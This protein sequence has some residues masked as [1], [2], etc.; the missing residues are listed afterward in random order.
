M[1]PLSPTA[2][3]LACLLLALTAGA[4]AASSVDLAVAGKI[5]P[6]ACTPRLDEEVRLGGPG[7][8]DVFY[9]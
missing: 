2:F 8:L 7:T 3:G 9:L 4:R 6:S 5:T 1:K